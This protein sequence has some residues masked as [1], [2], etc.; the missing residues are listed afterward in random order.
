MLCGH[1]AL[2]S[3]VRGLHPFK[4]YCKSRAGLPGENLAEKTPT[5]EYAEPEL[6]PDETPRACRL[7]HS[8][9]VIEG[10]NGN[11]D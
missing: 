8:R 4:C 1:D 9:N 2:L 11:E 10:P 3:I 7:V 5:L 6:A